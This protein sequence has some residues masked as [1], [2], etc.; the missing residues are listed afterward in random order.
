MEV[1]FH[2]RS[3]SDL[4][5]P[6][7]TSGSTRPLMLMN[8][9]IHTI[10]YTGIRPDQ[11]W[12]SGGDG[13]FDNIEAVYSFLRRLEEVARRSGKPFEYNTVIPVMADGS[14]HVLAYA[15]EYVAAH[16][17]GENTLAHGTL[18]ATGI[19]QDLNAGAVLA[20]QWWNA[21]LEY[22]G[23]LTANSQI[24]PHDQMPDAQTSCPGVPIKNRLSQ[25]RTPYQAAPPPPPPPPVNTYQRIAMAQAFEFASAGRWDTRGFGNFLGTG[26]YTCKLDGSEGKVG[27]MVNLT[28]VAANA[29]GFA[30]AWA[31]GPMPN[32]SC[33]NWAP[34][35]VVANQVSVPLA[36]DGTFQIFISNP[37]HIIIDLTGYYIA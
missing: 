22:S 12:F 36:A 4:G 7:N 27:A 19:G 15:D 32:K 13:V 20:F 31:S 28:I 10:H 2:L 5:V 30:T 11:V 17:S 21:V 18:F 14:A 6:T 16:S 37:A 24:L 26:A 29:A 25:L 8:R 23:R 9:P 35:Q 34:G 1:Q 33:A 3:A